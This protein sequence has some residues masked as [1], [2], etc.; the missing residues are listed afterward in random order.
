MRWPSLAA[1]K[2]TISSSMSR[3]LCPH[4]LP[5]DGCSCHCVWLHCLLVKVLHCTNVGLFRLFWMDLPE[6][7]TNMILIV[8]PTRPRCAADCCTCHTLLMAALLLTSYS[9][10]SQGFL[11]GD[12]SVEAFSCGSI[13]IMQPCLPL[14]RTLPADP[15]SPLVMM[16]H[17]NSCPMS[18]SAS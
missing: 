18:A 1:H 10:H 4:A 9:R 17:P 7:V 11:N 13:K 16:P 6:M 15:H 3:A 2:C 5:K 12:P 8:V 14:A